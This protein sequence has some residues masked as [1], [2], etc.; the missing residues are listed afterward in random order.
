MLITIDGAS[1]TGKSTLAKR[2]ADHFHIPH[3]D[4]GAIYRSLAF[5]MLSHNL[6]HKEA[7]SSF[8]FSIQKGKYFVGN[9]DVS[10]MIRSIAVTKKST[11]IATIPYVRTA[12]IPIQR[13]CANNNRGVFDGRDTGTI[14][15]PYADHKFYLFACHE[16]RVRRRYMEMYEKKPNTNDATYIQLS[17]AM[18]SRDSRDINRKHSPLICPEGAYSLDTSKKNQDEIFEQMI[19]WIEL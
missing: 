2:L 10:D 14:V 18:K 13:G 19:D 5:H 16:E 6:S 15:I 17:S 9:R 1:G 4:T 8:H 3:I 7:L 12:L 11:E